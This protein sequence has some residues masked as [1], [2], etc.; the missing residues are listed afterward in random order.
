MLFVSGYL[1]TPWARRCYCSR[2]F[3]FSISVVLCGD[4]MDKITAEIEAQALAIAA[5]P[6][7]LKQHLLENKGYFLKKYRDRFRKYRFDFASRRLFSADGTLFLEW[8]L[9][10]QPDQPVS[11]DN[12]QTSQGCVLL[13][14]VGAISQE[15]VS[16]LLDNCFS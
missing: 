2:P 5:D 1:A 11:Y 10:P 15:A 7:R 13:F 6:K 14:Q 16:D 9:R 3:L 8:R 4:D 12:Q